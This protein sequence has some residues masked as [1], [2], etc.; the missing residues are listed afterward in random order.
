MICTVIAMDALPVLLMVGT[1]QRPLNP[2]PLSGPFDRVGVDTMQ[3]PQTE[4]GNRCVI[5]FMDYLTLWVE[6]FATE[7]QTSETI[8]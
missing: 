4:R 6:A 2:I 1:G 3:M 5:V 8:A 7:D